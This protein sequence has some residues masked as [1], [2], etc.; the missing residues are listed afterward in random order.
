MAPG[1][2]NKSAAPCSK[3]RFFGSKC[4]VLKKC[5]HDN[6]GIICPP[7]VIRFPGNCVPLPPR[8]VFG[9]MEWK[10]ENFP[11]ANK[12][13]RPNLMNICNFRKQFK[14][15]ILHRV[16]TEVTGGISGFFVLFCVTSMP[17]PC[18]SSAWTCVC[19]ANNKSFRTFN[20]KLF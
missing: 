6:A 9:V 20:K 3:L 18:V 17:A 16:P 12:F 8:H 15:W 7:A 2:I 11:K 14:A 19:F 13:S 5:A 1:A 10:S 4:T